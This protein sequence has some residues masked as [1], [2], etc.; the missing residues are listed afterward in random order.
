MRNPPHLARR[1][2]RQR[3]LLTRR[4]V[5]AKRHKLPLGGQLKED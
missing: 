5:A 4:S 3:D 1:T 2:M